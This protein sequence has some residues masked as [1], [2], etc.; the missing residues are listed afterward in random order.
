[1]I[2]EAGKSSVLDKRGVLGKKTIKVNYM[3]QQINRKFIMSWWEQWELT[4]WNSLLTPCIE[5]LSEILKCLLGLVRS[6]EPKYQRVWDG[7][8]N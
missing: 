8:V 4:C 7:Q 1:M 5:K 6:L 2:P 3:I